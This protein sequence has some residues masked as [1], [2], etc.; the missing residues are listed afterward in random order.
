L[1]FSHVLAAAT[2]GAALL[3]ARRRLTYVAMPVAQIA[4]E[5][6][7]CDPAYFSRFFR[8]HAGVPPDRFRRQHGAQGG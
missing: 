2:A 4:P 6:G 7:F 8:R 5:L 1:C 3:E